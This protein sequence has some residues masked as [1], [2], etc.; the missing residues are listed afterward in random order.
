MNDKSNIS[1]RGFTIIELMVVISIIA[2]L[3]SVIL[4][5]TKQAR[6]KAS[7]ARITEEVIDLRNVFEE[8]WN[9]SYYTDFSPAPPTDGN[10][11]QN[12]L[13]PNTFTNTDAKAL[14]TDILAQNGGL[15]GG[16]LRPWVLI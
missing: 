9:G 15:Y 13:E 5:S 14:I 11:V 7:N 3:S 10:S 16:V 1:Q 4:A 6:I 8:G 2:L 12:Y